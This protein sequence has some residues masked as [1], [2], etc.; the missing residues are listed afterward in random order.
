MDFRTPTLCS[1][2]RGDAEGVVLSVHA[3]PGAKK[4]TVAGLFDGRLKIALAAPPVDGKANAALCAFLA[5]T[6]GTAKSSV[7]LVSG[8]TSREKRV[9]V[10]GLS[11]EAAIEKIGPI[12]D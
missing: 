7:R 3:R 10:A 2:L 1:W 6:L 11:P 5:E 9:R 12:E 4:S 8:E